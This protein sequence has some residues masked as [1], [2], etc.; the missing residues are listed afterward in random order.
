[1]PSI[2]ADTDPGRAR[3]LVAV[4]VVRRD[5]GRILLAWRDARRHQGGC[6]EFPGGKVHD[7]E[8]VQQALR[9]ELDEEVGIIATCMQPLIR[10]P[11]VYP[12][13]A[14]LLDV[15]EVTAFDGEARGLEGQ[16]IEWVDPERL[17][18]MPLPEANRPIV[19]AALLPRLCLITPDPVAQTDSAFLDALERAL[20]AGVKLVQLRAHRLRHD[21]SRLRRLAVSSLRCCSRHGAQLLLNA[22]PQLAIELGVGLHLPAWRLRGLTEP[23]PRA[24]GTLLGVSCHTADELARAVDIGAD[25]AVLG[26][27]AETLTHPGQP[28]MGF[29]AFQQLVADL[30][31]PVYAIGG[32][33][34]DELERAVD[35]GAQGIAAIRALWP[36]GDDAAQVSRQ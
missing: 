27:V 28:G 34:P 30:P 36:E 9:R 31:L 35:H 3:L 6:W 17:P 10:I 5:D 7:D 2:E 26:P 8:S 21:R 1:M 20:A 25:F 4:G 11:H 12:E 33:S 13:R 14:V 15:Y 16:R 24:P 23:P 29:A 18:E 19:T 22:D 32:M